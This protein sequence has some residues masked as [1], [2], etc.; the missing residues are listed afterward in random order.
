MGKPEP[1][2]SLFRSKHRFAVVILFVHFD[3]VTSKT[4]MGSSSLLVICI[5]YVDY[6]SLSMANKNSILM[7]T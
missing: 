3:W 5:L 4:K 1:Q 7:L 6:P 2:M